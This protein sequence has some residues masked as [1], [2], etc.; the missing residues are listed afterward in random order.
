MQLLSSITEHDARIF[1]SHL[2]KKKGSKTFHIFFFFIKNIFL[3]IIENIVKYT[4]LLNF[5]KTEKSTKLVLKWGLKYI[6]PN[7]FHY[8]KN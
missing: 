5:S 7:F 6:V 1:W 4:T 2:E 8:F 3:F